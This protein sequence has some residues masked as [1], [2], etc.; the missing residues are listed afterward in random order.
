MCNTDCTNILNNLVAEDK[1]WLG[2]NIQSAMKEHKQNVIS[3]ILEQNVQ[4]VIMII[5]SLGIIT[6]QSISYTN[7]IPNFNPT[8][9]NP[10]L[11]PN[12]TKT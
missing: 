3:C 4:N 5:I 6:L 10:V 11:N 1:A 12:P 8:R 2:V 9:K 7:Q